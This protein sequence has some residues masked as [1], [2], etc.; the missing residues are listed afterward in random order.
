M[1]I[2]IDQQQLSSNL[3]WVSRAVPAR[4]THPILSNILVRADKDNQRLDLT[5]FDLSL[6]IHTCFEAEIEESGTITVPA[7]LLNDIVSRLPGGDIEIDDDKS[8]GEII[9]LSSATSNYDVRC[10]PADE[11]PEIPSVDAYEV[12]LPSAALMSGIS[13]TLFSVSGDEIKQTLTGVNIRSTG[14]GTALKFASTDGHRL[15]VVYAEC[16]EA[17][18][19]P[20]D[21]EITIPSK[22]L[23]EVLK[24]VSKSE[25]VSLRFDDV[26]A[27][28]TANGN[29]ITTRKLDG[30]YPD[31]KQLIPSQFETHITLERKPLI[32]ALSRIGVLASQKN[33]II[34][35][36]IDATN[37]EISLSVEAADVG[38]A[39]ESMPAQISGDDPKQLAFNVKYLMEGLKVFNSTE[40]Q[41][42][43]N[44][45][46]SPVVL[47]P[48]GGVKMTYLVMPVQLRS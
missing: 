4:P 18:S 9:T 33:D 13:G 7:K 27:V 25:S 3:S 29:T 37:Q 34:K 43:L 20:T 38:N 19:I 45:A 15:S 11:Y 8:V 44:A 26:Q 35:C 2:I 5:A 10:I 48:F 1:K 17:G 42:Q 22:A 12:T 40:I 31:Y 6:G 14:D 46:T 39:L 21:L 32:D 28:F 23:A 30:A 41:M 16:G 36:Q 24:M 47:N